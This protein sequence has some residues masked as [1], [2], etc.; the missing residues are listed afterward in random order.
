[1][2]DEEERVGRRRVPRVRRRLG[3]LQ[4]PPSLPGLRRLG[5]LLHALRLK[6]QTQSSTTQANHPTLQLVQSAEQTTRNQRTDQR[7]QIQHP[8]TCAASSRSNSARSSNSMALACRH[9]TKTPASLPPAGF[10]TSAAISVKTVPISSLRR[11]A[12]SESLEARLVATKAVAWAV[13]AAC[14]VWVGGG[15]DER[16]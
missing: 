14:G 7:N 13:A 5:L 9:A 10:A 3:A 8:V 12:G 15:L 11:L 2:R 4:R 6:D 1:M 16:G